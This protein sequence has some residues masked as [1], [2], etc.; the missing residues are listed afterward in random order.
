[1]DSIRSVSAWSPGHISGL[2]CPI[3]TDDPKKTGSIGAGI[4]IEQGVTVTVTA[5]SQT[6]IHSISRTNTGLIREEWF[7]D[8][9]LEVLLERMQIPTPLAIKTECALPLSSGFGLSAASLLALAYAARAFFDLPFSDLDCATMAHEIEV[10]YRTGFG[11]IAGSMRGGIVYRPV[12]GIEGGIRGEYIRYSKGDQITAL[13]LGPLASDSILTS[14]SIL[15]RIRE[16]F[17][18]QKPRTIKEF[19]E[20][21]YLFALRSGL[22]SSS[23]SCI[24]Q[25]AQES[26]VLASMTMLGEGVFSLGDEGYT[27]LCAHAPDPKSIFVCDIAYSGPRVIQ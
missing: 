3:I 22:M 21:S 10:L 23:V 19:F 14:D 7:E 9:I 26:G 17:P 16:A 24:L 25:K 6:I 2:F 27:F 11:D 4:A 1:M 20:L 15:S 18:S 13:V 5:A 8:S 12:P